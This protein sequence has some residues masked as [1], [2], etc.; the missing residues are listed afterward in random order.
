MSHV[1]HS[2]PPP[3]TAGWLRQ[4]TPSKVAA[5]LGISP[6]ESQFSLWHKM[7]GDLPS[8][9]ADGDI[10]AWGHTAEDSLVSWWKRKN[11]GWRTNRGEIAYTD[12]SLPFPNLATLD[13]RAVRGRR[14]AIIECK[15]TSRMDTWGKPGEPHSVPLFYEAQVITQMGISGIHEAY[16]VVL[17]Y[18]V[19]EI[20]KVE[21]SAE[22]WAL[23]VDEC[24]A[25]WESLEAGEPP[26]LSD[27]KATYEAVRGLHPDIDKELSIQV[28]AEQAKAYLDA[29]RAVD[30]AKQVLLGEKIRLAALMGNAHKALVGGV[31]IADRRVRGNSAPSI[32]PNKK[33]VVE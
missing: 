32:Y 15:T 9:Q 3:G 21:W 5:I 10:F 20:H 19:P 2:P 25:W 4:I 18:G 11:P 29:V 23:I 13:R 1:L 7:H 14:Y 16:V 22:T 30:E 31:Q 33:A 12:P 17:G 28:T 6:W 26:A 27:E 24:A 8:E